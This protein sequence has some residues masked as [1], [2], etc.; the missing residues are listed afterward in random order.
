MEWTREVSQGFTVIA[1]SST[2]P[3]PALITSFNVDLIPK[4]FNRPIPLV[5]ELGDIDRTAT[6]FQLLH[7]VQALPHETK[8]TFVFVTAF[9]VPG[10]FQFASH[11]IGKVV[12]FGCFRV[13]LTD[14]RTVFK[15]FVP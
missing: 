10:A 12:A 11:V 3:G 5:L 15:D 13:S 4:A 8:V 14:H 2:Q 1:A 9:V 7:A 6:L